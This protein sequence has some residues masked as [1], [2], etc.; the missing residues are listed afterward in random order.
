[1]TI[2]TRGTGI[3]GE[4]LAAAHFASELGARVLARNLRLAGAEIDLLVEDAGDLVAVEVK[5]RI[6]TQPALPEEAVGTAKLRRIERALAAYAQA[7]PAYE[8]CGWR[9]DV[10]AI[11]LGADGQVLRLRHVRDAS[12]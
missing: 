6:G 12:A 1:M 2:R 7:N 8:P 11:T 10:V 9:I 5:T 4:D 3:R